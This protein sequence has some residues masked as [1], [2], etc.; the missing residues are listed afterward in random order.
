MK[1][2]GIHGPQA[3]P[4][5]LRHG[6]AVNSLSQALPLETVH[7]RMGNQ[8]IEATQLYETALKDTS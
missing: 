3:T 7:Y 4:R 6:F 1:Q 5:G 2:A 8:D